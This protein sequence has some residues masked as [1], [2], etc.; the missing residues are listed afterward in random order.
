M[1]DRYTEKARRTIF[2][3]RYEASQFGTPF[4]EPEHLPLG[5][6]RESPTVRE[7]IGGQTHADAFFRKTFDDAPVRAKISTSV[8][9][10]LSPSS[11]RILALAADEAELLSHGP[12]TE[13]HLLLGILR[14]EDS[15]AAGFLKQRDV[16]LETARAKVVLPTFGVS[17][18]GRSAL[19]DNS[20][21]AVLKLAAE[22]ADG[23]RQPLRP[24]HLLLGLLRHDE[25][26]GASLLR[27]AGLTLET[28][29][30]KLEQS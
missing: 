28:V 24:E 23:L 13:I 26:T 6:L 3:A 4:I 19:R 1:F 8:D 5:I 12:I 21:D 25:S 16:T 10:P 20:V 7:L 29:R 2:F 27:E 9:L 17:F 15:K 18:I 22:E 30:E 11:K 14:E